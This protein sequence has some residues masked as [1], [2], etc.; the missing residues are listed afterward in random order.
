MFECKVKAVAP[1][2]LGVGR[3]VDLFGSGVLDAE[4]G[5]G[6]EK[7]LDGED[8]E[9]GGR[10]EVLLQDAI[11]EPRFSKV[12]RL[13]VGARLSQNV[14]EEISRFHSILLPPSSHRTRIV[15]R[16]GADSEVG[17]RSGVREGDL[18]I[19]RHSLHSQSKDTK[20]THDRLNAL[21]HHTE[22]LAADKHARGSTDDGKTFRADFAP[23]FFLRLSVKVANVQLPE[24]LLPIRGQVSIGRRGG[25]VDARVEEI[26]VGFILKKDDILLKRGDSTAEL[27]LP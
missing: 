24:A 13:R 26:R 2:V 22:V 15:R 5:E 25:K 17:V 12:R 8:G 19:G 14:I 3:I 20:S 10:V 7:V 1:V 11:A 18:G 21:W 9:H 23:K 27:V 6:G 4:L 16:G